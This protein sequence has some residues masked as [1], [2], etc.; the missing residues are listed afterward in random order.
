MSCEI[1]NEK[2]EVRPS[3][4][5]EVLFWFFVGGL[6]A[7]GCVGACYYEFRKHIAKNNN[8]PDYTTR[9]MPHNCR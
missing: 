8:S 6:V 3:R 2:N 7:C 1:S 5:R 9:F 4:T